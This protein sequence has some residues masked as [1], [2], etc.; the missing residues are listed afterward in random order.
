MNRIRTATTNAASARIPQ[1]N[2]RPAML[3][4]S[5][6]GTPHTL[7][8][9]M[10]YE[11]GYAYPLIV[12]MHGPRD[13]ET[14]LK[15]IMPLVS[16]RNYVAVAPRGT[17]VL[18]GNRDGGTGYTWCEDDEG[19]ILAEQ[20]VAHC[21]R[22]ASQ[23]YHIHP[24]R[25]FLAGYDRGGTMAFRVG[26]SRPDLFAGILSIGGSFPRGNRPLLRF[27]QCRDLPLFV[28]HGRDS[29]EY[30]ADRL[31][32]DLRLFHTAGLS[33]TL[34]QYPC[35]HDITTQ[36]LADMNVWMMEQVT[37]VESFAGDVSAQPPA[38]KN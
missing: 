9:P 31:C 14:Q 20:R 36:M 34:R 2:A 23:R 12:W 15:R 3:E 16:M 13:D 29:I 32:D 1:F 8:A 5:S 4:T 27:N 19:V 38:E 21:I 25:V 10:H 35:G 18:A 22:Q 37:G 6:H 17:G 11:R 24:H 7:F 30:A 28:A 26:F 33:V